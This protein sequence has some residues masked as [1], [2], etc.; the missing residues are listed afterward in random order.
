MS[1]DPVVAINGRPYP[2]DDLYP[3]EKQLFLA[4]YREIPN[5]G[6]GPIHER[7]RGGSP[8]GKR[9]HFNY[10]LF[11]AFEIAPPEFV[12]EC[13]KAIFIAGPPE[14]PWPWPDMAGYQVYELL[15]ERACRKRT[16]LWDIVFH[17]VTMAVKDGRKCDI[18][19]RRDDDNFTWQVTG[20]RPRRIEYALGTWLAQ[21]EPKYSEDPH[22]ENYFGRAVH[23]FCERLR[24]SGLQVEE[25]L[26]AEGINVAIQQ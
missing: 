24:T 10:F 17:R 21:H 13:N 11:C 9:L 18:A 23:E 5:L 19:W 22:A 7:L 15:N 1:I 20:D 25:L 4:G 12:H 6:R 3:E 26:D 16:Q 14:P 8:P 2:V